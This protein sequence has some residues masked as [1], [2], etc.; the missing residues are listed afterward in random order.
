MA[1]FVRRSRAR[2]IVAMGDSLTYNGRYEST[3]LSLLGAG[4]TI[5]NKGTSG[6]KTSQML[7]RF[8]TDVID[9]APGYVI[10]WG[11]VNDLFSSIATTT[12]NLAA[13][14]LAAQ[15]ANIKV[16]SVN[17][18][19]CGGVVY[20]GENTQTWLQTINS[21]IATPAENTDYRVDVYSALKDPDNL[22]HLLST[23]DS[24]DHMHLSNA[25]YDVV[26]NAIHDAVADF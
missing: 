8:T 24:G 22:T 13:M 26:A 5:T 21:W 11:G 23:Y 10:I 17:I 15:N 4:W 6:Q 20:E 3:L 16:I 25:G 2:T 18:S 9:L 19:P 7:E 12:S 14:Y 1:V